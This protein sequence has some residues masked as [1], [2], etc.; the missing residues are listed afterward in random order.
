MGKGFAITSNLD[1]GKQ[2]R[3][4]YAK[5][6]VD[7]SLPNV[8][9]VSI[10]NDTVATLIAFSYQLKANP[11]RKAAMGLVVGT[12][13]NATIPI[14]LKKLHPSKRPKKDDVAATKA[15]STED[16]IVVNT[17][18]SINGAAGPLRDLN[19]ITRWD[20]QL[21][22]S[23]GAP[24]FQP[25]EYMTAGRYL[26]ELGRLII[27]EYFT[28]H[29]G[30]STNKLPIKLCSQNGLTTTFLGSL[31]YPTHTALKSLQAEL[32]ARVGDSSWSWTEEAAESVM[33]VAKALEIRAAAMTAASVIGLLAC[34][35]EISLNAD[36]S[37]TIRDHATAVNELIIGY[38]GLCIEN[39][40][41]FRRD[42]QQFLDDA[43]DAEFGDQIHPKIILQAFHDGGL[44]GAGV[45]AGTAVR[46]A[47]A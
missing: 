33:L 31:K 47:Q 39:F 8:K 12:G 16:K 38:T 36:S 37:S 4:G 23:T 13:T 46:L 10:V 15:V 7:R 27:I 32:P 1:L 14:Q 26:G 35:G 3:A 22:A 42:C 21:D 17:E 45:L 44:V 24:G 11:Q 29:L 20:K 41:D 9:L 40:Q 5:A 30:I 18:W 2:L 34:A 28:T 6:R 25:I 19:L 43:M